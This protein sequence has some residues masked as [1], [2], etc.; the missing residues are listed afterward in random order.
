MRCVL[1]AFLF[2]AAG[3]AA[4]G[5]RV[6]EPAPSTTLPGGE[7][8]NTVSNAPTATGC[9]GACDRFRVCTTSFEGL[10]ACVRSCL[11]ELPDPARAATYA[12]CIQALSCDELER[13]LSMNYGPIGACYTKAGAP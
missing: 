3:S 9:A 7:A 4:C 13:G 10:E 1:S 8:S 12:R 11:R 5:G 6:D 2:V